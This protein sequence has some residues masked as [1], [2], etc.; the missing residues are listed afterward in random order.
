MGVRSKDKLAAAAREAVQ[1]VGMVESLIF[2]EF[3]LHCLS[4]SLS[5][6]GEKRHK[7]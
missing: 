1:T 2:L 7:K 6:L 5:P 4:Q 3:E